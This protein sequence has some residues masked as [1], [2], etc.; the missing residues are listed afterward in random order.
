MEGQGWLRGNLPLKKQSVKKTLKICGVK[1][2]ANN[3][4]TEK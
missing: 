1:K 4:Q 2:I 3:L